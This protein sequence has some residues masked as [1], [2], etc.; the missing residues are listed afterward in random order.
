MNPAANNEQQYQGIN[1]TVC[2]GLGG[3]GR[4]VLMRIRRLIVDKYGDLKKLP[5]VSF[6]HI[7]TDKAATQVSGIR[8]GSIYHG[9]DLS[10]QQSEKVT[11]TMSPR[12][13][14]TFVE[15]LER[16]SE[17]N[18]YG[19]YDHIGRWFPPQLLRNIKAVEEGAKGIR[20]VGRL[21]FFHNH[22]K[23]QLAINNA[24]ERTRGHE[25]Y[26]LRSG[27]KVEPGLSIFV[28]GSLCGGTGSGMFLDIAYSLRHFYSGQGARF[29]GY[30]VIS[31]ELYGNTPS[32]NAN[33]YAALK[34]LDY[35]NRP[36]TKFEACYDIQN[37]VYVSEKRSPFDYTYLVSNQTGGE[38]TILNQGKLCN[39]IAHKISLDFSSELAPII[40]GNR[41][42]F[43]QHII[44]WDKHPRPNPQRYLTFGL[45]AIY[46]RRD[47]VVEISL[48]KVGLELVNFWLNGKSQSPD[49]RDLLQQFLLEYHWHNDLVTRDGLITKLADG[50]EEYNS[51]FNNSIITWKNKINKLINE[52]ENKEDRNNLRQK[53]TKEFRDQFRK[54]QP[55]ET[56]ST[57][58]QWLTKLMELTPNLTKQLQGD[59]DDY[60]TQLLTPKKSNF[61]LK[62]A[63]DWLDALQHEL[64]D[65]QRDIQAALNDFANMRTPEDVDRVWVET[66]QVLTD[67]EA[68]FVIPKF[69]NKNQQFQTEIK[70][71]LQQVQKIIKHNF[72]LTVRQEALRVVN[73]L[74]RYVQDKISQ[75]T[76]F[77]S[78]LNDLK[79]I[80]E[81]QDRELR[82]LNFDEMS[83]E[84]IFDDEDI[85]RCHQTMLPID[86][87]RS[88]LAL[89][90]SEITEPSGRGRSL[91]SFLEK[92]RT[93]Q[94]LLQTEMKKKIDSMF[95]SRGTNIVKS[96]I[97]RFMQNYSTAR[98]TR[99][100]Q[101]MEE[102]KPLLP[103]SL[104]DPYFWDDPGKTSQ[105]VGFKDTDE[106]EVRQFKS[107]LT[108][109]LGISPTVL[110]SLQTE[111]EI[112]FV[113]EYGGF[114]LRLINSLE[115]MRNHYIREH[116]SRGAC[117]HNDCRVVFPDIMPP[118]AVTIE[119]LEN[120]FYPC[121]GLQLLQTNPQNQ[122]LE[123][124]YYD[125]MRD[126]YSTAALSSEWGQALEEL[127]NRQDMKLAL[128]GILDQEILAMETQPELWKNEYLP[129]IN[130]FVNEV[131]KLP[132]EHPN[133]PYKNALINKEPGTT[134]GILLRF[135][136]KMNKKFNSP[137]SKIIL[138]PSSDSR[139]SIVGEIV[140]GEPVQYTD[141]LGQVR[142]E[143]KN[144]QN[145]LADN[146][147]TQEDYEGRKQRILDQLSN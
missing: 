109:D 143:L 2:I 133:Y 59:M 26:L 61:S 32:M 68:K 21:A 64:N 104:S 110:K 125:D 87:L 139:K 20:P 113:N 100:A 47:A 88:Q 18:D 22:Q 112:V 134:E 37:P 73:K 23:I 13:V 90:S 12:E 108:T 25:A 106:L 24:E 3:T 98:S 130:S 79:N 92:E 105:L 97:K 27:L 43:L 93:T 96:V 145:L 131:D 63:R 14:T 76:A 82:D 126:C 121:L 45:S 55:G 86:D 16:R 41:D 94:E 115:R 103:L 122:E 137:S 124:T 57:R 83:G 91:T 127:A 66:D 36:G 33:T 102:A 144:L 71:A 4:D 34:E 114:P 40:K 10:F 38:Y 72:D 7:D 58:G 51:T 99:L 15:G 69:N 9:V 50:V 30:L 62:S 74:Q 116:N 1:R 52:C 101:I 48:N 107:L 120:V 56:E 138:Q 31:P 49:P 141:T 111:D 19:P 135:R 118:D 89:I 140:D 77:D 65:Y 95:A 6:V 85:E 80:Y 128:Q 53:L 54:V 119:Q 117:L 44:D 17:Y 8:T 60:L 78:L 146:L 123:F 70:A 11:A 42:N 142:S 39:V 147:I 81:R 136:R 29:C 35:Y 5:I 46:F 84:A 67:I 28:V 132:Q 75:T 129:K